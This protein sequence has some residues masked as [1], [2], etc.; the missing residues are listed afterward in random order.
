[1]SIRQKTDLILGV[2]VATIMA[3]MMFSE[4]LEAKSYPLSNTP[5]TVFE[6]L[7]V[8]SGATDDGL[9]LI[10]HDEEAGNV[11]A[12][13]NYPTMT[14]NLTPE[15]W[16]HSE[17]KRIR[18]VIGH[19]LGHWIAHRKVERDKIIFKEDE[20]DIISALLAANSDPNLRKS[21]EEYLKEFGKDFLHLIPVLEQAGVPEETIEPLRSLNG[22]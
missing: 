18:Y 20:A 13:I 15:I 16:K 1:M 17:A 9:T 2:I 14:I 5:L 11:L 8:A 19:E 21:C 12:W 3:L 4:L 6:E 7:L 10:L 22:K